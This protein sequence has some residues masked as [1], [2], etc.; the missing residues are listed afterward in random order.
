MTVSV[1]GGFAF[2][3]T[4][5]NGLAIVVPARRSAEAARM[6]ALDIAAEGWARRDRFVPKLTSRDDAVAEALAA[7]SDTAHPPLAFADVADNPGGGGRGNTTFLLEALH[8][9]G[10]TG[11]LPGGFHDPSPSAHAQQRRRGAK[12]EASVYRRRPRRV[13]RPCSAA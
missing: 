13:W 2:A 1:M 4:A 6:L 9:A 12:F 8:T 3:D 11:A 5:K 10:V 7:G